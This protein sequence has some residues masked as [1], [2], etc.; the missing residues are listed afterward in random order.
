L[1]LL[2]EHLAAHVAAGAVGPAYKGAPVFLVF[3]GEG[4]RSYIRG[5]MEIQVSVC[6]RKWDLL[7]SYGAWSGAAT[8]GWGESGVLSCKSFFPFF[9]WLVASL[10]VDLERTLLLAGYVT[11]WWVP[12]GVL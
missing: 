7:P 9:L 1:H 2:A 8:S 12:F 10:F 4:S 3:Q 11:L 6:A 5:S